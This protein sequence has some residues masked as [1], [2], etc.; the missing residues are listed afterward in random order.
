MARTKG[1]LFG[2]AAAGSL[3]NVISYSRVPTGGVAKRSPKKKSKT[4]YKE[5][6]ARAAMSFL[7][8]AWSLD[9]LP[10]AGPDNWNA[11]GRHENLPGYNAYLRATLSAVLGGRG[12]QIDVS[13]VPPGVFPVISSITYDLITRIPIFTAHVTAYNDA[14][15]TF[16]YLLDTPFQL[17]AWNRIVTTIDYQSAI[18]TP[19]RSLPVYGLPIGSTFYVYYRSFTLN[20]DLE[21]SATQAGTIHIQ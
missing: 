15:G 3:G 19:E 12:P 7:Q 17:P 4:T 16:I 14:W 10:I 2:T 8:R 1:P 20:G 6:N 9:V 11:I 21:P 5:R 18:I 13:Y